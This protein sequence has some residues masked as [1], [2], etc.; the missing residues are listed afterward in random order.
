MGTQPKEGVSFSP[1]ELE[2]IARAL[3]RALA[4]AMTDESVRALTPGE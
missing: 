2:E 1:R 3:D 4:V